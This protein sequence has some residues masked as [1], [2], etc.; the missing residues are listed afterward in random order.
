VACALNFDHVA[1]ANAPI[2]AEEFSSEDESLAWN[3]EGWE[4][5]SAAR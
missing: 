1:L 3:A 4:E 5:F 2:G